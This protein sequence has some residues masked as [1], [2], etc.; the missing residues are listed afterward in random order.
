MSRVLPSRRIERRKASRKMSVGATRSGSFGDFG[1]TSNGSRM[2]E[3]VF[4]GSKLTASVILTNWFAD[5]KPAAVCSGLSSI[6]R[7]FKFHTFIFQ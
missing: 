3:E 2:A 6:C 5:V 7:F 4:E 1:I